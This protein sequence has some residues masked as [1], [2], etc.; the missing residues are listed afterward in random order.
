MAKDN[1]CIFKS[2]WKVYRRDFGLWKFIYFSITS[3]G[4]GGFQ[5]EEGVTDFKEPY[6]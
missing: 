4:C 5:R 3:F 2:G 1:H 6:N